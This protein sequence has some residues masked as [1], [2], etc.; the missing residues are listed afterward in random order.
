[1]RRKSA[2]MTSGSN[3]W[4]SSAPSMTLAVSPT[5]RMP[6]IRFNRSASNGDMPECSSTIR[7]VRS[8]LFMNSGY[9]ARWAS[10]KG[11]KSLRAGADWP[12]VG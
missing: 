4:A 11:R 12:I 2:S 3:W 5:T 7:T 10:S 8:S 9:G 1:V 6:G